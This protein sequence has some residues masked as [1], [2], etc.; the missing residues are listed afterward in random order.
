MNCMQHGSIAVHIRVKY[1]PLQEGY[2]D[3]VAQ[4]HTTN[5]MYIAHV[6]LATYLHRNCTDSENSWM[7]LNYKTARYL[8]AY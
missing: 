5:C 7:H 2:R 1:T 3:L 6:L 4:Q 8:K